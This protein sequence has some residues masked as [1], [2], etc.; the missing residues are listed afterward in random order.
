MLLFVYK[1]KLQQV[2]SAQHTLQIS[3]YTKSKNKCKTF[4]IQKVSHFAK[5]NTI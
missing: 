4:Y 2:P 3:V 5:I 1:S